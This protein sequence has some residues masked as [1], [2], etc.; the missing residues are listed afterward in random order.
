MDKFIKPE[1][2]GRVSVHEKQMKMILSKPSLCGKTKRQKNI[3]LLVLT[4]SR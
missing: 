3:F 2:E 4:L 1:I